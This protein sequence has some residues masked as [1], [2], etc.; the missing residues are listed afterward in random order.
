MLNAETPAGAAKTN[1][2]S[3]AS[4]TLGRKAFDF[5]MVRELLKVVNP[6]IDTTSAVSRL[7]RKTPLLSAKA[8]PKQR[9]EPVISSG[10]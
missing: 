5:R 1:R 3:S 6:S 8:V 9:Q 7:V 10:H 4:E 2:R